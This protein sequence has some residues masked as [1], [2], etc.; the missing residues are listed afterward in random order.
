MKI[1]GLDPATHCGWAISQNIFGVWDLSIKK[2]ESDSMRIIRFR[3]KLRELIEKE[4]IELVVFERPGGFHTRSIITQSELQSQIKTICF[5]LK[6]DH[7]A[8]S[9]TEIKKI[10]TGKGNA[11]KE[12]MIAAAKR[13]FNY[14][15]NNDNEADALWIWYYANELYN[16]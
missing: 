6:V 13:E 11:N 15:G 8:F 1:L 5:D 2:D 9:S 3:S 14:Q 10:A 7:R 12:K 4:G 16:N